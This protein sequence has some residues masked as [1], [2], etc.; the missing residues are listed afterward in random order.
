MRKSTKTKSLFKFGVV[1][2]TVFGF[3]ASTIL[4]VVVTAVAWNM[5]NNLNDSFKLLVSREMKNVENGNF[6]I[7]SISNVAATI[8]NYAASHKLEELSE[9]QRDYEDALI[10]YYVDVENAKNLDL[11]NKDVQIFYMKVVERQFDYVLDHASKLIE[12]HKIYLQ[13]LD[14]INQ[15]LNQLH[16]SLQALRSTLQQPKDTELTQQLFELHANITVAMSIKQP[17]VLAQLTQQ[18]KALSNQ[19]S[20]TSQTLPANTRNQMSQY[21]ERA[22]GDNGIFTAINRRNQAETSTQDSLKLIDHEM[23]I[24]VVTTKMLLSQA[25]KAVLDS[26]NEA[27]QAFQSSVINLA[28]LFAIALVTA[29]TLTLTIP[30]TIRYPLKVINSLLDGLSQGDLSRKANYH[31]NDEFGDLA[32]HYDE[33]V[34]Q[35]REIVQ[36]I[37]HC[38]LGINQT[39]E[40]NRHFTETLASE[41]KVQNQESTNVAEAMGKIESSFSDVSDSA[42]QTREQIKDAQAIADK[43][44]A[45]IS[46][47]HVI[48]QEL[49]EKLEESARLTSHVESVSLDIGSIVDVIHNI[50]EQT[51]LLAL[52]A[53]I[54]AARA[55][56]QGRG[57]A[58]VA[59]E[60]RTLAQKTSDSTTEIG[61][62]ISKLQDAVHHAVNNMNNCIE[63][64]QLSSEK[65]QNVADTIEEFNNLIHNIVDMASHIATASQTQLHTSSKISHNINGISDSIGHSIQSVEELTNNGQTLG[66][67]A[68]SQSHIVKKFKLN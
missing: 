61:E 44:K 55:G 5:G 30:R 4:L 54:E 36:E 41:I 17:E 2:K 24:G 53:A 21:L 13:S 22:I 51:N 33:T 20:I 57:F 58:V 25:Y 38:T 32:T 11:K 56:E 63:S 8:K 3:S 6:L 28:I 15:R 49:N 52:N 1:R 7:E 47:N 60:V 16:T 12:S 34:T 27:K 45:A 9:L 29:L 42:A 10:N 59:D 50:S 68:E 35:L 37:S 66:A 64:M 62:M 39:A 14:V 19:L 31:K 65:N 23:E 48:N 18:S 67:L 46:E 40:D 26:T 43:G